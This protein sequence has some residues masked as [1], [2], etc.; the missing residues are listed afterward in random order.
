MDS[1]KGVT[2]MGCFP[3]LPERSRQIYLAT[4]SEGVEIAVEVY[5]G[6]ETVVRRGVSFTLPGRDR[7]VLWVN[8]GLDID[9]V[10]PIVRG[11]LGFDPDTPFHWDIRAHGYRARSTHRL[12][13]HISVRRAS[14][15]DKSA[16]RLTK[17]VRT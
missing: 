9:A 4:T 15:L 3:A 6:K 7:A 16:H 11:L 2:H 1:A 17:E 10:L 8:H 5:E 14:A 13:Y 12:G